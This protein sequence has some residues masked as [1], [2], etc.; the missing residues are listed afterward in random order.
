MAFI[1]NP[2]LFSLEDS[3]SLSRFSELVIV[4]VKLWIGFLIGKS[5][6]TQDNPANGGRFGLA[7]HEE[8]A[9][10]S[11]SM[12]KFRN[13]LESIS[14]EVFACRSC[15]EFGEL[16]E[17]FCSIL[18]PAL[19]PRAET[20]R[21]FFSARNAH[22]FTQWP[23]TK[24]LLFVYELFCECGLF[25]GDSQ[26]ISKSRVLQADYS[27]VGVEHVLPKSR[28]SNRPNSLELSSEY[29][30]SI[31]NMALAT[32]RSNSAYST[33]G[34]QKKRNT[35]GPGRFGYASSIFP[36]LVEISKHNQWTHT[37]I[38]NRC[39]QIAGFVKQLL[40]ATTKQNKT[41]L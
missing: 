24:Y 7:L 13:I 1:C 17:Y 15:S 40:F 37:Q 19:I 31:G 2:A 5:R 4:L 16:L 29:V 28:V 3:A 14:R 8:D 21:T 11:I 33:K 6:T 35:E 9:T 18:V 12:R 25:L 38:E 39:A 27:S 36:S 10:K 26:S 22:N 41:R 20:V 32:N 34:F 23:H 30:N